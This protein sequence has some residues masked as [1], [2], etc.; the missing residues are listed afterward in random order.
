MQQLTDAREGMDLIM[1]SSDLSEITGLAD[2]LLVL[3]GGSLA[4]TL[5]AAEATQE[6]IIA[7]AAGGAMSNKGDTRISDQ[8]PTQVRK[9]P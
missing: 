7:H 4:A 5:T 9:Q 1:I 8:K 3:Y 6:K 2:R